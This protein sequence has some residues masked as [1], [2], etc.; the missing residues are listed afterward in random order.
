MLPSGFLGQLVCYL[1][2]LLGGDLL[3]PSHFAL[4]LGLLNSLE[5]E[6]KNQCLAAAAKSRW[7][8]GAGTTPGAAHG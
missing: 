2:D 1:P 5:K 6:K 3:S 7:D 4:Q 8:L